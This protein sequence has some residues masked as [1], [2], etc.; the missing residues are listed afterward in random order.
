ML[1][2]SSELRSWDTGP[3]IR[4]MCHEQVTHTHTNSGAWEAA[5]KGEGAPGA[6]VTHPRGK[7]QRQRRQQWGGGTLGPTTRHRHQACQAP[8]QRT[9]DQSWAQ[10]DNLLTDNYQS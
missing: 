7:Q 5:T 3:G 8:S 1:S 2:G 4:C 10:I 9:A 6:V